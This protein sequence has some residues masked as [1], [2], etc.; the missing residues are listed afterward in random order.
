VALRQ[1]ILVQAQRAVWPLALPNVA[2]A[3]SIAGGNGQGFVVGVDPGRPAA[4]AGYFKET[5]KG[6][7]LMPGIS[8]L[9][10]TS[11]DFSDYA[12]PGTIS[13]LRS[14]AQTRGSFFTSAGA[15]ETFLQDTSKSPGAIVFVDLTALG[16]GTVT[17]AGNNQIGTVQNPTVLV[18][19]GQS[20][21]LIDW[22]GTADFYGV[23][24]VDGSAMNRGSA[25]FHGSILC[26]GTLTGKGNGSTDVL[27]NGDI[28]ARLNGGYTINVSIVPN[29]WV[30]QKPTAQ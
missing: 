15:A 2:M 23:V 21:L 13:T 11:F 6:V 16:S 9:G 4:V 28:I 1:R 24:I 29:T 5:D 8:R 14:I 30:E 3:A 18:L 25:S 12:N 10:I 20:G 27:Y 7:V 22:R 17:M 19:K 26:S